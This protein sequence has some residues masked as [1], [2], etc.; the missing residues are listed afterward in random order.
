MKSPIFLKVG[1]PLSPLLCTCSGAKAM[2]AGGSWSSCLGA[3]GMVSAAAQH[4]V[5]EPLP[6][7]EVARAVAEG[8]KGQKSHGCFLH[9]S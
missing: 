4:D 5:Q 2:D 3:R 1:V 7:T 6:C 8:A 9:F